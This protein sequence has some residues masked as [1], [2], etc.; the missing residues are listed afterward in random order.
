MP[1]VPGLADG[2]NCAPIARPRRLF[3]PP[4]AAIPDFTRCTFTLHLLVL[5]LLLAFAHPAQALNGA[6]P[7]FEDLA[8]RAAQARNQQN[9]PQAIDLYTRALAL[10]PGW[11]EGWFYL[12]VVQYGSN[13]F[14]PAIDSFNHLLQL[15]PGVPAAIAL[16]GLCEFETEAYPD[17]LRD[18]EQAITD[19]TALNPQNEPSLRYHYAQLLTRAGRFGDALAQY[20]FF[21]ANHIQN[22]ELL[23][24]LAL[25]G[26][27]IQELPKNIAAAD[28][29]MLQA[30]G[31]AAYAFL[32]GDSDSAA[33][34]FTQLF[35]RYPA[36]PRLHY[37]YGSFI[38]RESP[39]IAVS[40]F[41]AELAINPEN[42]LARG[43]LAFSLMLS[44]Q[45]AESVPEAE[46]ALTAA[47]DMEVAQVALGH[48]LAETG[49]LNRASQIIQAVLQRDP[50]NL[51]AHLALAAWYARSGRKEDAYHEREICL[52]MV[53]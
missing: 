24:G 53:K 28:R 3:A 7:Q 43:M 34:L 39:E 44:G 4:C 30:T 13:L 27:R 19:R 46:R 38:F 21:I 1:L 14:A 23:T 16:R 17:S 37:L 42:A 10:N 8:G 9:L 20:Q 31:A 51:E 25:A 18:L 12:G 48:S 50:K 29:D 2:Q 40:E 33:A 26:L 15:Q 41:R 32:G 36:T 49:D 47:P 22:A 35:A 6:P 5:L 52:D 45:F 11:A